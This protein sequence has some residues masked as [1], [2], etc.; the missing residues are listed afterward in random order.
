[1]NSNLNK[2]NQKVYI[3]YIYL[4]KNSLQPKPYFLST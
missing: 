3:Y 4:R 2:N 1:M